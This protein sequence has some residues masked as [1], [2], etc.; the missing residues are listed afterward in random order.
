MTSEADR[1]VVRHG[2]LNIPTCLADIA[3]PRRTALLVY[4]MQVGI[5]RQVKGADAIIARIA[6]L[7]DAARLA[8]MRIAYSRH[9][10]LSRSWMGVTQMRMAM[11]WQRTDDPALVKPW[12]LRDAPA[13]QIVPEL[14]PRAEDLVFD[15]VAMSALEGTMLPFAL[16]DAG[17]TGLAIAGIAM[18]I[19]IEPTLRHASDQGFV[20]I[21]IE[22]ACGS[23]DAAAAARSVEA[24]RFAGDT[25]ITDSDSFTRAIAA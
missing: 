1:P 12:F 23:G 14:A 24:L 22:D 6:G 21:L 20:P 2:A 10:S 25:I 17:L 11:A 9:L 19:G 15:K 4:D 13:T 3:D 5:A 8:G 7:L 16:R 18:E